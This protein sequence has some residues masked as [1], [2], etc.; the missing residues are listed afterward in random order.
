M[1]LNWGNGIVSVNKIALYWVTNAIDF[2]TKST[3]L[4][5]PAYPLQNKRTTTSLASKLWCSYMSIPAKD[6]L[7]VEV[8]VRDQEWAT[9][10]LNGV[11][12]SP[13]ESPMSRQINVCPH[14]PTDKFWTC[15]KIV[16]GLLWM[17]VD[18]CGCAQIPKGSGKCREASSW[19]ASEF[20]QMVQ[21]KATKS[22]WLARTHV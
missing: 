10:G 21:L 15:P 8:S 11:C 6:G 18:L 22:P 20:M 16:W 17:S 5:S 19:P 13:R 12:E 4:C 9:S 2:S 3:R 14:E 1:D 7:G